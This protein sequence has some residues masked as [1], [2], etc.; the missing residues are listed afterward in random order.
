MLYVYDL[1]LLNYSTNITHP[2]GY[3]FSEFDDFPTPEELYDTIRDT[4]TFLQEKTTS[5]SYLFKTTGVCIGLNFCI[6]GTW[7]RLIATNVRPMGKNKNVD[8][9]L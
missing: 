1:S 6:D 5:K 4:Y 3:S 9:Y 2:L 8:K 7:Y